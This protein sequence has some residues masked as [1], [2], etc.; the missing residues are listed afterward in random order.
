M[1]GLLLPVLPFLCGIAIIQTSNLG[2]AQRSAQN[3]G[4]HPLISS[5][6][7]FYRD[8]LPI[9]QEHCQPCHHSSGIAPMTFESYDQARAYSTV[10][11]NITSDKGMPPPF[12]IPEAGRIREDPSLTP[13][14]ISALAA[15]A[16]AKTPA[17]D[18]H[19]ESPS[20]D[21][22]E[23]SKLTKP[24]VVLKIA[25]P[26]DIS[27]YGGA[28]YTYEIVP[29]GF[30]EDRWVHRAEF[31]T[32]LPTHVRQAV[33]FIR[34]ASSRWLR[35]KPTGRPFPSTA[36]RSED[37]H[38][39]TEDVLVV[40]VSGRSDAGWPAAMAKLIPAGADFVF[41]IQYVPNGHEGT[42]QGGVALAFS[43]SP[44]SRRV[45]T[46]QL[47]NN[48]FV[49]PPQAPEYRVEA[50]GTFGQDAL[51]LSF[52]P[53]MHLRGKRLEYNLIPADQNVSRQ[54]A[55]RSELLLR[56]HYDLRWQIK[57][58]LTTPRPLK[59]GEQLQVI[60]WYD[61]SPTNPHNPDANVPVRSGDRLD[62]EVL[63]GFFDI[64]VPAHSTQYQ[65]LI[66]RE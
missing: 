29:T 31:L 4:E 25:Q 26:I 42:D 63:G 3:S 30:K 5:V 43:K 24:D 44:P 23:D 48:H 56:V 65:Y 11:R 50:H 12:A 59:A 21:P 46:L 34:P 64:A 62:E 66:Q 6:P 17:G 28:D 58:T 49:I 57:Y 27:T 51:L 61:N 39:T 38:L 47:R 32:S 41:R 19:D 52:F 8:I 2:V 18:P 40:Y 54:P 10:I 36:I 20:A 35:N 53:D 13:E 1:G 37:G 22:G 55:F 16:N 14:Q 15:W 45:L 60:A 7:T 33:I 9:L